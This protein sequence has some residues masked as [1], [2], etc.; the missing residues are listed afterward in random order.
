MALLQALKAVRLDET[1][2]A[3]VDNLQVVTA[4][5]A[6]LNCPPKD[7]LSQGGRAIWNRIRALLKERQQRGTTT[8][9]EWVH[10]HVDDPKRRQLKDRC[11]Q[12]CACGGRN[13]ATGPM[14]TTLATRRQTKG[15]PRPY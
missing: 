7:R 12:T 11:K 2:E 8:T 3:F 13:H 1:V 6:P 15:Q 14:S 9:V 5:N 4:A 10:S